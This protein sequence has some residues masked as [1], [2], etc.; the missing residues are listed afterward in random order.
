MAEAVQRGVFESDRI[1][2]L[3]EL[4]D[5]LNAAWAFSRDPAAVDGWALRPAILRRVADLLADGIA[6]GVD[7]ILAVGPGAAMIGTAVGL[8]SGLP[9]AVLDDGSEAVDEA[10]SGLR[11][12]E[13]V[14]VVAATT[15]TDDR[16]IRSRLSGSGIA[17]AG[18]QVVAG[19]PGAEADAL[20][21][22][23]ASGRIAV[24]RSAKEEAHR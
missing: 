2:V 18:W 11:P 17:L 23:D 16:R 24:D 20:F 10:P 12:G 14:A 1:T 19:S 15:G 9:F 3:R 22:T 21:G 13:T 8:A 4:A 7:R 6:P 5:D